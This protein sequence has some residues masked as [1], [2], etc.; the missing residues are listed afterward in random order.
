[1]THLVTVLGILVVL[2]G[3]IGLVGWV[4]VYSRLN[5]TLSTI[6]SYG[7]TATGI[8]KT[9]NAWSWLPIIGGG[10]S[11]ISGVSGAVGDALTGFANVISLYLFY[12]LFLNVALIFIGIALIDIGM[13][14]QKLK[15]VVKD[16]RDY[17]RQEREKK[18]E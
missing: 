3:I 2:I 13:G 1:M 6:N 5:G 9:A 12:N 8:S 7:Q 11:T 18:K 14:H 15:N 17:L 16:T 10:L 4:D